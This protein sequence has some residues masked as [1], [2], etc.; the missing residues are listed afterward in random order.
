MYDDRS[1]EAFFNKALK[2]N[3]EYE[4]AHQGLVSVYLKR[5]DLK[6]AM[7]ELFKGV[8]GIYSESLAK[9]QEMLAR[10]DDYTQPRQPPGEETSSGSQGQSAPNPNVPYE[11]LRLPRFPSWPEVN[12][13]LNDHSIKKVQD[14]IAAGSKAASDKMLGDYSK[15]TGMNQQQQAEWAK[16]WMEKENKTG[17]VLYNQNEFGM[18]LLQEYFEDQL[19]RANKKYLY[20]DS[21]NTKRME[22]YLDQIT[23][24]DEE[25]MKQAGANLDQVQAMMIE[26]CKKITN[27]I[28]DT[29]SDWRNYAADRH[30]KYD[31]A[32]TTYW[33][34]CEQY[35]NRT[36]DREEFEK[37]NSQ[38][39]FF[40]YTQFSL[41]YMDYSMRQFM[42]A[43]MNMSAFATVSGDCPK[44]PPKDENF[45]DSE[46]DVE[47]PDKEPIPCPFE[48]GKAK[49]GLGACSMGLD[50][51]NIEAECGEGVIGAV[52]W[53]Y[54]KK[55]M[56]VFGGVGGKAEFGFKRNG[57]SLEAKSGVELTFNTKGQIVDAGVKTEFGA[58]ASLGS[59][60][61]GQ[62][63][64][65]KATAATGINTERTNELSYSMF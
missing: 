12:A 27:L 53:N 2:V 36:Y 5:K 33:I 50:C 65:I 56:T 20:S 37:L 30:Y 10:H 13:L 35:L 11:M 31:D 9:T 22:K 7:E 54:K 62:T 8:K 38:R 19:D 25:R 1:A 41:L 61:A 4:L 3:P 58:K 24:G 32:L 63:L 40:V 42:F 23:S 26:R 39:K 14:Q 45:R 64:E 44:T 43:A 51:E 49:L 55:E 29:Y 47:V 28:R 21:I 15:I 52:K 57:A 17:R 18:K 60:E 59:F 34:Y 6:K 46:D 48:K 16:T